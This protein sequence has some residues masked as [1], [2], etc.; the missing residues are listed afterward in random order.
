MSINRETYLNIVWSKINKVLA[1]P[2]STEWLSPVFIKY[3]SLFLDIL[4]TIVFTDPTKGCY[5]K[6][7]GWKELP[8]TKNMFHCRPDCGS[9]IGNHTSQLFSN[10]YLSLLYNYIKRDLKFKH[11]GRYID[12]FY[13]I[14]N[15]KDRLLEAIPM[16][17][18]FLN[19]KLKL[20]LHL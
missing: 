2:K 10:I 4:R 19:T 8:Q 7:D 3:S 20:S 15:S 11:Y 1:N 16:I 18:Q 13:I 12:D 14:D 17:N 5:R 9:P 6:G